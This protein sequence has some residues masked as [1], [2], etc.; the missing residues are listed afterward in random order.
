[1]IPR[2]SQVAMLAPLPCRRTARLYSPG[3]PSCRSLMSAH[4]LGRAAWVEISR[5]LV[6]VVYL[7]SVR[8]SRAPYM[9][10]ACMRTCG[11][12]LAHAQRVP[13]ASGRL[14]GTPPTC[15]VSAQE[16]RTSLR[17]RVLVAYPC[18]SFTTLNVAHFRIRKTMPCTG[19][20]SLVLSANLGWNLAP[21][22]LHLVGCSRYVY[23]CVG[24]LGEYYGRILS[25]SRF[26]GFYH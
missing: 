20:G 24:R 9:F 15:F 8:V 14:Q 12:V 6:S 4:A 26:Q 10:W 18:T 11:C 16:R 17:C 22:T 19:R 2:R 7:G 13:E 5:E 3:S 25:R 1:M 23:R 21:W